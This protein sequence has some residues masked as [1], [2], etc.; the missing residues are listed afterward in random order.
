LLRESIS[1]Q[2]CS[3]LQG[4]VQNLSN[5]SPASIIISFRSHSSLP[6]ALYQKKH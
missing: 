1:C 6:T 5:R 4:H 3:S 2:T